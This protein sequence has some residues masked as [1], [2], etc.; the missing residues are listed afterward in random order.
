MDSVLVLDIDS[1]IRND[2]KIQLLNMLS[3][4]VRMQDIRQ[5]IADNSINDYTELYRMLYDDVDKF[6][7]NQSAAC[8]VAIAEGQYRDI[9]VVDK[10]INF[11]STIM[12]IQEI[13][14]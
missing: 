6:S 9:N 1:V 2:Y 8:I 12:K 7:G 5:L 11:M 4:K 14:L 3:S 10:E 13:I